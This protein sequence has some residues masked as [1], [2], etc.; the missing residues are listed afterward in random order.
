VELIEI[1]FG[2]QTDEGTVNGMM[3]GSVGGA[4]WRHLVNSLAVSVHGSSVSLM[5]K[6]FEH[7]SF[8]YII[9]EF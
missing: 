7:L 1:L 6:Y 4:Y 3:A 8:L 2:L 5:S 9:S